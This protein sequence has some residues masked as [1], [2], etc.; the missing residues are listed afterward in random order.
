MNFVWDF[1]KYRTNILKHG[2]RFED[3]YEVFSDYNAIEISDLSYGEE[4]FIRLGLSRRK[5]ILVV[6][7]CE[8]FQDTIRIISARKA[9]WTEEKEYEERIRL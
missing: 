8:R 2:I 3:T 1:E 5:G 4:R 6:V 7:Y 9:T